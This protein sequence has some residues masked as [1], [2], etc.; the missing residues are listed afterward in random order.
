LRSEISIISSDVNSL[1]R[2]KILLSQRI[3]YNTLSYADVFHVVHI[4]AYR[5][6]S[7]AGLLGQH[8][9]GHRFALQKEGAPEYS[10]GSAF[11]IFMGKF[12]HASMMGHLNSIISSSFTTINSDD[13]SNYEGTRLLMYLPYLPVVATWHQ[14]IAGTWP[15]YYIHPSILQ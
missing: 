13:T 3:Y 5:R 15:Q 10:H 6:F 2:S 1:R 9:H 14:Q 12:M 11:P 8:I 4:G 7:V